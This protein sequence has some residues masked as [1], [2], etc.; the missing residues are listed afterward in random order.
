MLHTRHF[1]LLPLVFV[2]ELYHYGEIQAR[3]SI[4]SNIVNG[5]LGIQQMMTSVSSAS[6]NWVMEILGRP[7]A[8]FFIK[9][10]FVVLLMSPALAGGLMRTRRARSQ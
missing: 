7:D 5:A 4:H 10:S 3:S 8:T 6:V 1:Y 9:G 2:T